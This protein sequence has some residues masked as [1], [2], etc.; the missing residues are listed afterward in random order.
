MM[1]PELVEQ[2]LDRTLADLQ[3]D[4]VD[5]YLIHWPLCFEGDE[6]MKSS[7]DAD[8]KI[9]L[10]QD[11]SISEVWKVMNKM[12]NK[13]KAKAVGVSNFTISKLESL[14]SATGLVPAVNQVELHPYL[15]QNELVEY[16]KSKGI[17]IEA[18]SPLGAGK[19]PKLLDDETVNSIAKE[20]G[21]TPAQVLISWALMRDT[22]PLVRTSKVERIP[23][24]LNVKPLSEK[25]MAAINS[26]TKRHR[27]IDPV[28]WAGHQ[29]FD[30]TAQPERKI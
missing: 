18:Y 15:P 26:I 2:A 13:G 19:E 27:Y 23:E 14:I 25:S 20:E 21:L 7:R 16:C 10:K 12:V 30:D 3:L 1:A 22:V 24:N 4:Y 28:Q 9:K 11:G 8:G 5:L 6:N 17:L 29:V